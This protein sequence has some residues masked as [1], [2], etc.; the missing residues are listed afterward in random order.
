MRFIVGIIFM[1]TVIF[2]SN[3]YVFYRLWNMMP[4]NIIGRVILI[5]FAIFALASPFLALFAGEKFPIPVT[6]VMYK[7]GTSWMLIMM[8]LVIIFLLLDLARII[9]IL[10]VERFMYGSWCGLGILAIFMSIVMTLGFVNYRNKNREELTITLDKKTASDNSLKIVAISDLHLGYGISKDEFRSWVQIINKEEPDVLL[11]AGDLIDNSAYPLHKD[12][13]AEVFKEIR[14]K[15]GIY[16]SLGNHEYISDVSKSIKFLNETGIT[17]LIDS[18]AIINDDYYI[19][20]RDDRSHPDR[21]TIA[22]LIATLDKSKPVIML[23]HQPYNLEDVEK[24]GIDLQ[25]SGHTHN[26]QLWP[27]SWITKLMYEKSQ[28]YIKKGNSNIY[29]SSGIG[30]WGGKFRIGTNSEYAVILMMSGKQLNN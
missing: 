22:D 27:I 10:P 23:D 5:C 18:V 2:G 24:N 20:G 8:Y 3:F 4:V 13:Y 21:K 26:G 19:V 9:H 17:L 30:I 29:I 14:T 15:Y 25:I 16:M 1:I 12:G 6:S 28:G 11:I 7:T